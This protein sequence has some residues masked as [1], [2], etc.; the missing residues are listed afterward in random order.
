MEIM[1]SGR[2]AAIAATMLVAT[3]CA[4]PGGVAGIS[5]RPT[6]VPQDV[7]SAP[8]AFEA[9]P[10]AGRGPIDAAT[11]G[12]TVTPAPQARVTPPAGDEPVRVPPP[13]LSRFTYAFPVKGCRATYTRGRLVL[14]KATIWTGKGCAFVAPVGGVVHEVNA[15]NRWTAST[16][17]GAD[18]EGRFVSIVGDDGVRYLGGHLDSVAPGLRPGARVA[19]GQLLGRVGDSGNAKDEGTNLYFAVSW[20]TSAKYWWVR[21]GMVDPWTYLDAWLNGNATLSPAAR[22]AAVRA[23]VGATPPCRTLCASKPVKRPPKKPVPT[24]TGEPDVTRG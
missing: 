4:A 23:A 19:A 9:S 8:A 12:P 3:A 1:R 21:R 22:V 2:L 20:S 5:T 16:D 10:S 11:L 6:S 14:P 7:P 18:R 13:K 24:Q 15:R 17:R